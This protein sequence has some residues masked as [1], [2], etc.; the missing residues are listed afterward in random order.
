[1]LCTYIFQ[2]ALHSL[3]MSSGPRVP[4]H[5]ASRADHPTRYCRHDTCM[6]IQ[7][8]TCTQERRC[9]FQLYQA[10]C[11]DPIDLG[12]TTALW[13]NTHT[14]TQTHLCS[15]HLRTCSI[16][17]ALLLCCKSEQNVCQQLGGELRG[18]KARLADFAA[19]WVSH[20]GPMSWGAAPT[21]TLS[22]WKDRP[23]Q[24][25]ASRRAAAAA[26][27]R[28]CRHTLWIDGSVSGRGL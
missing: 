21:C 11:A 4:A 14:H 23:A 20:A 27:W 18:T 24:P 28:L 16:A 3:C 15:W 2:G 10:T 13:V 5:V 19:L 7:H 1:M 22:A 25:R 17:F 26:G 12:F 6:Y 9:L 8:V